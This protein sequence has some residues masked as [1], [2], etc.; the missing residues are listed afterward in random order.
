[1]KKKDILE[2]SLEQ[3]QVEILSGSRDHGDDDLPVN[4]FPL[5]FILLQS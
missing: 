4:M 2:N 1:M 5:R 3:R